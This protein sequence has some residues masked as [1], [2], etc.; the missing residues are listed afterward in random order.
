[1]IFYIFLF[2]ILGILLLKSNVYLI[3]AIN[4][5]L[6]LILY[7]L[8]KLNLAKIILCIFTFLTSLTIFCSFEYT[9]Q[10]D[11]QSTNFIIVRSRE[12]YYI[13]YNYLDKFYVYEKNNN[14]QEGDIIYLEGKL[15]KISF[16]TLESEFSFENYLNEQGI[17]NELVVSKEKVLY[18]NFLQPNALKDIF[19]KNY[20]ENTQ[21]LLSSLLFCEKNY[22]S[23]IIKE[24]NSLNLIVCISISGI[25]INGIIKFFQ[26]IFSYKFDDKKSNLFSFLII[27]PFMLINIFNISILRIFI[28]NL[29]KTINLNLFNKRFSYLNLLGTSG[30]LL[31]LFDPYVIFTLNFILGYF[32]SIIFLLILNISSNNKFLKKNIKKLTL[33][34]IALF[35]IQI[36]FTNSFNLLSIILQFLI[37]PI[38]NCVFLFGFVSFYLGYNPLLNYFSNWIYYLFKLLSNFNLALFHEQLSFNGLVFYYFVFYLMIYL[39]EY[40]IKFLDNKL[41]LSCFLIFIISAFPYKR[42]T[43]KSVSFINVGQGDSILLRDKDLAILIDTGGN[44]YKDIANDVLIN[45]FKKKEIYDID[46]LFITHDDYD[47]I[48]ALE[49][50]NKNF[51]IKNIYTKDNFYTTLSF[52]NILIQN[53]N[54][55]DFENSN[56][57]SLVLNIDFYN[58]KFLL[59]GDASTK[60]ENKLI[61]TYGDFLKA[62]Y[63]KLGHHGSNT[64]SSNNFIKI[65]S[66]KE[67]IISCGVNNIY[68]HPS[69][70]VIDILN[71]YKIK[72]RRTDLEGTISYYF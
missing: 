33:Q 71:K 29:L 14:K 39:F 35:P 7:F 20:D 21:N 54:V 56:D 47:H 10:S 36:Y 41:I 31:I 40:K 30:L 53:L 66:P 16:I 5:L 13:V 61:E 72:I 17:Y 2:V 48:G 44:I 57:N 59:M 67:A 15:E 19:L 9:M 60:V 58:N 62:D 6:L 4:I 32:L 42:I 69:K 52:N 23:S 38:T 55:W 3:L 24:A 22:D 49:E 70:Q 68:N 51:D 26:F 12:N 63:L 11:T 50:L 43:E 27:I 65:V 45:F 8:K 37:L 18:K 64:S 25:F 1:M 34:T 28:I 46:Y